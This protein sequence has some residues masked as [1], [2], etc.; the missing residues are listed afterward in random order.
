MPLRPSHF[1]GQ[2]ASRRLILAGWTLLFLA[3][4]MRAGAA[5]PAD[6]LVDTWGPE[7]NLPNSTVT[8]IAQ[9]PDGYIW[10][11]T[12]DGLARFDGTRFVTLGGLS[13][14]RI[15]ELY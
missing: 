9:T 15:Q 14:A 6:Y 3:G 8:S 11:G 1:A 12:Y 4:E 10:A 2:L 13:H 7:K 5:A